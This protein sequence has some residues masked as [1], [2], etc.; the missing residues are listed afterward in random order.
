MDKLFLGGLLLP[1]RCLDMQED[2]AIVDIRG[3][4]IK[5]LAHTLEAHLDAVVGQFAFPQ[6][7]LASSPVE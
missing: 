6:V 1:T 4:D 5:A 2:G 3:R 7:A